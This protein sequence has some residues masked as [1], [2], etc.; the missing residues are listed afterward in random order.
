MKITSSILT[1]MIIILAIGVTF[2]IFYSNIDMYSV[3]QYSAMKNVLGQQFNESVNKA[4]EFF[5]DIANVGQGIISFVTNGVSKG[6][7][8][9]GWLKNVI[10]GIF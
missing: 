8:I 9:L 3:L 4:F 2:G 6:L 1:F 5:D 7:D 10:T